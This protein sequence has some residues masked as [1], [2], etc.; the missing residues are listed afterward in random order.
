MVL[1]WLYLENY[2]MT[3][4]CGVDCTNIVFSKKCL[5]CEN[6]FIDNLINEAPYF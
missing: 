1:S 3:L 6:T 5:F 4:A 2:V